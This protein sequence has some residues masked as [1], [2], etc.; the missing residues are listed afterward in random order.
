MVATIVSDHPIWWVLRLNIDE[1]RDHPRRT[2][3]LRHRR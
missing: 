2:E 3:I 1:L